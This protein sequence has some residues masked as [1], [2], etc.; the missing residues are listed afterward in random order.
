MRAVEWLLV[1]WWAASIEG[2]LWNPIS[3]L[4]VRKADVIVGTL[5]GEPI[6]RAIS[7]ANGRYL[8]EGLSEGKYRVATGRAGFLPALSPVVVTLKADEVRKGVDIAITTPAVITGHVLDE[9]G[10]PVEGISVTAFTRK[11]QSGVISLSAITTTNDIGEYR[12][13]GLPGGTYVIRTARA[14]AP[15]GDVYL[16]AF[17]PAAA[18]WESTSPVRVGM[19]GEARD[20][21]L[22]VSKSKPGSIAGIVNGPWPVR[23][24]LSRKSTDAVMLAITEADLTAAPDGRFLFTG[25]APGIYVVMAEAKQL[26]GT[27][28]VRVDADEA[29]TEIALQP[30]G[31]V[32]VE[33]NAPVRAVLT[34]GSRFRSEAAMGKFPGIMPGSWAAK[35]E[36]FT[37][38]QVVDSVKWGE[39]EA[40][41]RPFE[42]GNQPWPVLRIRVRNLKP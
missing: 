38:D 23:L 29:Q 12:F 15:L 10:E 4:P 20:I 40:L 25:L 8:I 30:M 34:R 2:R 14:T 22:R 37:A 35:V 7:D 28:E 39:H 41:G 33:S 17:Y 32:R 9:E 1:S 26:W 5:N 18:G 6:K 21:D 27:A 19:G 3:G 13:A 31:V 11:E 42:I 36:A 24:I 16:P